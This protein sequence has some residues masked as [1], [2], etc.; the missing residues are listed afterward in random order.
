MSRS[1]PIRT[2]HYESVSRADTFSDWLFY[3]AT[4][5]TLVFPFVE[6]ATHPILFDWVQYLFAVA[7]V[8]LFGIGLVS[9]LYLVPRAENMRRKDFF[10]SAM[11]VPLTHQ[12]TDGYYNNDLTD[13]SRR[14]AAQVLENSH[15]SKSI[16]LCMLWVERTK[17]SVYIVV[18]LLCVIYRGT[19]LGWIVAAT[20]VI[21]GEQLLSKYLRMEWLRDKCEDTY[22]DV[23]SL[24]QAGTNES[25]F[26]AA[27][28][29]AVT[30]YESAKANAG[31][32]LSSKVFNKLNG[33]LSIEWSEIK[34]TLNIQPKEVAN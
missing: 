22:K 24:F 26:K 8:L 3:A 33:K 11:G 13:P 5:L 9:R 14:M 19:D 6:R 4:A 28:L 21:F 27:V 7:V 25:H 31:I 30:S 34:A 17:I 16:I 20:Q 2:S 18:W 23:F 12:K 10:S 1:D 29:E 15:F 32:V